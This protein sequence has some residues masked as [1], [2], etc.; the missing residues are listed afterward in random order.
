MRRTANHWVRTRGGPYPPI[1][2]RSARPGPG[3]AIR[4]TLVRNFGARHAISN[5]Y[6]S[7]Q[8]NRESREVTICR[9]AL[10]DALERAHAAASRWPPA[11][12]TLVARFDALTRALADLERWIGL[13]DALLFR[14][15]SRSARDAVAGRGLVLGEPLEV[16]IVSPDPI[17]LVDVPAWAAQVADDLVVWCRTDVAAATSTRA[18]SAAAKR[19]SAAQ[20]R[21]KVALRRSAACA[22]LREQIEH[23]A[24]QDALVSD[25]ESAELLSPDEH[26]A[27]L[28]A[29]NAVILRAM[30]PDATTE[31]RAAREQV[32][33]SR[34]VQLPNEAA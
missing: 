7:H 26:A 28:E 13:I 5:P 20:A 30:R 1:P 12:R 24:E 10:V 4:R 22:D 14:G 25:L 21:A 18:R 17:E 32:M 33:A 29:E 15:E 23:D 8:S 19:S 11:P 9:A 34:R 3:Q 16:P 2:P 6:M 31:D 27:I